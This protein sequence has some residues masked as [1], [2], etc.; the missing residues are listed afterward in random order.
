M[1]PRFPSEVVSRAGQR[2]ERRLD[3]AKVMGVECEPV[4]RE[5]EECE[6]GEEGRGGSV[7]KEIG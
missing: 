2:L 6:S 5:M 7:D 3:P 1:P 4:K